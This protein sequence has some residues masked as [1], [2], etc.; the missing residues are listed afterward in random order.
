MFV[1]LSNLLQKDGFKWVESEG[2]AFQELKDKLTHAPILG[3][4]DFEDNFVI[5]ADAFVVGIGGR[6]ASKGSVARLL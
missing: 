1:P 4:P 5:E 2:K 3:L 6:V